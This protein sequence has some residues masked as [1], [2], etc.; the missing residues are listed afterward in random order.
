MKKIKWL[1]LLP[2]AKRSLG[3]GNIFAPVCHSVQR[4]GVP[5]KVP[6]RQVHSLGRYT[7][8]WAGTPPRQVPPRPGTPPTTRYTPSGQVHPSGQVPPWYQVHPQD[9]VHPP[10]QVS[11]AP[12]DQVHPPGNMYTPGTRY[13]PWD[14]VHPQHQIH[15]L[16]PGTPPTPGTRYTPQ[17]QV[18]PAPLGPGTSPKQ[19]MLEIR[20]T[21]GW[22]ASYWNAFLY[23]GKIFLETYCRIAH[24]ADTD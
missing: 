22:Y 2:P 15:P 20:A 13:T 16:G 17:D 11:P 3:E 1:K 4:W 7:P 19:C 14:Q 9:Q 8:L 10:D 6:P 5:G 18:H 23:I 12:Q 21:S 24:L